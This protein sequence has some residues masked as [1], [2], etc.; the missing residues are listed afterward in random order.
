ML[1]ILILAIMSFEAALNPG[2]IPGWFPNNI[3]SERSDK[4][5]FKDINHKI[6]F[7]RELP[8]PYTEKQLIELDSKRLHG[9][10]LGTKDLYI[11]ASCQAF[12][13][14]YLDRNQNK[15]YRDAFGFVFLKTHKKLLLC[16]EKLIW[17]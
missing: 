5:F 10:I 6:F 12:C 11:L 2:Q 14:E 8:F 7:T 13:I 15:D 4:E 16:S 17:L 3:L 1:Q 9:T